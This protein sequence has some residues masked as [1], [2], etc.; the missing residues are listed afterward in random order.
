M[1]YIAI[2]LALITLIITYGLGGA[3]PAAT[4]LTTINVGYVMVPGSLP[5]YIMEEQRF[6]EQ[7]GLKLVPTQYSTGARV[8]A[9]LRSGEIDVSWN[10][11]T[12]T[13]LAAIGKGLRPNEVV[14]V[15]F[16]EFA[17]TE[18]PMVAVLTK[19]ATEKWKALEH[20]SIAIGSRDSM[21]GILLRGRLAH[22]GIRDYQLV[23][24]AFPNM[25]LALKDGNV[26]AVCL[27]EPYIT[28]S[29]ENG[30]GHLLGW[31]VGTP[32][33]KEVEV[34]ATVFNGDYYRE[35][36]SAAK[37]FLKANFQAIRWIGNNQEEARAILA[38]RLNYPKAVGR[39]IVMPYWYQ[40]G[41]TQPELLDQFQKDLVGLGVFNDSVNLDGF[42]DTSLRTQ[43][44]Q[45]L[46]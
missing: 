40:D 45:E 28:R 3:K 1:R 33:F 11:G 31:V 14:P 16:G 2:G 19:T 7:Q 4:T 38:R 36:S 46:K 44:L 18:H 22:E 8:V 15:G 26:D 30:E 24:M 43:A 12:A 17:N 39:K 6:A 9:A 27:V 10:V 29:I 32:P 20:K 21:S 5:Y 23:E 25:E 37:A 13:L 41:R 34:S 35:H 42:Y